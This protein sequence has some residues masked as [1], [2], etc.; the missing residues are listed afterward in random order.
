M[1]IK[2]TTTITM[3]VTPLPAVRAATIDRI[4]A[5]IARSTSFVASAA[6]LD[7]AA[8]CFVAV[9]NACAEISVDF[10]AASAERCSTAV[11]YCAVCLANCTSR[12]AL[13]ILNRFVLGE[14]TSF[15]A[16][17]S[18]D[19]TVFFNFMAVFP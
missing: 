9:R 3:Q 1:P 15:A 13:L 16:D 4:L 6:R 12:A 19:I 8:V 18:L 7:M 11:A 17:L 2:H 5:I 14:I 10:T